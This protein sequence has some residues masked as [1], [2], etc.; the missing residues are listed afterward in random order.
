M[1]EL[2]EARKKGEE[3]AWI[4]F[5]TAKETGKGECSATYFYRQLRFKKR[6]LFELSTWERK[7]KEFG[8]KLRSIKGPTFRSDQTQKSHIS[9][10][11]LDQFLEDHK[12][13]GTKSTYQL[14]HSNGKPRF[15]VEFTQSSK[16]C[17]QLGHTQRFLWDT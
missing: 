8:K 5:Q 6:P 1:K 17:S 14:E 9:A 10:M 7:V 16:S 11:E 4:S 12:V 2:E 15:L 3:E 13:P